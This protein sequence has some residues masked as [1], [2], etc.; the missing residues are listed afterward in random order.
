MSALGP[1][2]PIIVRKE[3]EIAVGRDDFYRRLAARLTD[4][5]QKA[6]FLARFNR[7]TDRTTH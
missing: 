5:K 1:L 3:A 6:A 4:E 2:A 7:R